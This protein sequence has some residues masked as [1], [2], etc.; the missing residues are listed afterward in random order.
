MIALS[1]PPLAASRYATA[2][3]PRCK[4]SAARRVRSRRALLTGLAAVLFA[5]AGLALAVETN[6]PEW[7]DPEFFH[8]VKQLAA[9]AKRDSRPLVVI[10]GG[11]RPQTG[12]NPE[13]FGDC[14]LAHNCS[15]SGCLPVG[16]KLNFNRLFEAGVSPQF[17]LI[18]V[19]PPVL[20]DPG[21]MEARIP[22]VRLSHAD[23]RH[24]QA[25]QA[26]PERARLEWARLRLTSWHSLR[27]SLLANWGLAEA[28][29]TRNSP[30]HLW[31]AMSP[32]GWSPAAPREWR[33][34]QRETQ[35]Q[36]AHRTYS[37][38]LND[39]KIRPVNDRAYR[40]LL[41]ECRHR[42]IHAA[43]FVMPES[44]RFRSWYSRAARGQVNECLGN[45]SREFDIPL[46]D[47][48][49]WIDDEES[50]LDGHHLLREA[51]NAFSVRFGRECVVPW[52][53]GK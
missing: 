39:F 8:R 32:C 15:Q 27:V 20:A 35:I 31:S 14:V 30:Y 33:A 29:P 46:F 7:R 36:V 21:P 43:L 19:L 37:W 38:L 23:F 42:G 3:R 11:S 16:E 52:V 41:G 22:P 49:A 17:V 45:L 51:A 48:S 10:L 1:V 26:E 24:L 25:Y 18:E 40:D 47:C 9:L 5:H 28:F 34:E 2:P 12:L 50:F 6:R 13:A 44:L 4:R 53:R